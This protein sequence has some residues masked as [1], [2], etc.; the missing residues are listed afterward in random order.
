VSGEECG[1]IAQ[2][3][4]DANKNHADLMNGMAA[5]IKGLPPVVLTL[6]EMPGFLVHVQKLAFF[7][8]VTAVL[9]QI[10]AGESS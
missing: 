7:L 9:S 4:W 5:E 6:P 3:L 10:D 1:K 2:K 8:G